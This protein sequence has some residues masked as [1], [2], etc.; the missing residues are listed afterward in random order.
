MDLCHSDKTD[1][2]ETSDVDLCHSDILE[3]TIYVQK[4]MMYE[5]DQRISDMVETSDMDLRP[6]GKIDKV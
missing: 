2:V 6:S 3:I 1:K 5:L 4:Q